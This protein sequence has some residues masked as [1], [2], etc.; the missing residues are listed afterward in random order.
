MNHSRHVL[1]CSEQRISAFEFHSRPTNLFDFD[2]HSVT[3]SD[4]DDVTSDEEIDRQVDE[5]LVAVGPLQ[6][7]T[8]TDRGM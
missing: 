3:G 2:M 4:L 1:S 5:S 8:W 6:S 7:D